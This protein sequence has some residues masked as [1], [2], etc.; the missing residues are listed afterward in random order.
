MG[1]LFADAL[2]SRFPAAIGV[3]A[4]RS[5]DEFAAGVSPVGHVLPVGHV[6]PGGRV[7]LARMIGL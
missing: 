4:A 3:A 2:L 6:S 7:L 1:L 5:G